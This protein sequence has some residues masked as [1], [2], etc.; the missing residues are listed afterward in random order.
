M[1]EQKSILASSHMPE[2]KA[3]NE[4][5][6]APPLQTKVEIGFL[7]DLDSLR[8]DDSSACGACSCSLSISRET[9]LMLLALRNHSTKVP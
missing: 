7:N 8:Y 1:K 4:G 6:R 2:A 9:A 5:I 3:P